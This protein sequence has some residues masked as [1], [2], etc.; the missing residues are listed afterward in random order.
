M[1]RTGGERLVAQTAGRPSDPGKRGDYGNEERNNGSRRDHGERFAGLKREL[2]KR[3]WTRIVVS[4]VSS[5]H[6]SVQPSCERTTKRTN[7]PRA[8][9]RLRNTILFLS[10]RDLF[11]C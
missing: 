9:R 11:H 1:G 7:G 2:E 3:W 10:S 5:A 8:R 4:L 6:M